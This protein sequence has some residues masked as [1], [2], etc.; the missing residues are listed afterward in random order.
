MAKLT[1]PIAAAGLAV[2]VLVNLEASVLVPLR[3]TGGGPSPIPGSGL[4]DTGSD[5]TGVAQPILQQLGIPALR[6][7]LTQGIGGPVQVNLYQIS[8]HIL[9]AQN[10][11]LP[12]YSH[13]ALVVMELPGGFPLD[14]LIGMD[15]LLNCKLLV[16]G[17]ARQFAL[18]F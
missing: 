11:A 16:D 2:D 7:A 6:S 15:V 18:E 12:W 9:D 5:I 10:V 4:I 14:V 1:F 8:L 17:P 3:S 13:P